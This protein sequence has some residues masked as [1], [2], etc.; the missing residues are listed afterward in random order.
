VNRTLFQS[1]S[2]KK[3]NPSL[4]NRKRPD[5]ED[6]RSTIGS[7]IPLP[8]ENVSKFIGKLPT[9][10]QSPV[11][12]EKVKQNDAPKVHPTAVLIKHAVKQLRKHHKQ[13]SPKQSP[14]RVRK[15]KTAYWG[16]GARAAE[17]S[18]L[19]T[20][21]FMFIAL[22]CGFMRYLPDLL[23]EIGVEHGDPECARL[24]TWIRDS[25][26]WVTGVRC[27]NAPSSGGR[28]I[29]AVGNIQEGERY[30]SIP[31]STWFWEASVKEFSELS[32]ILD[33]DE[34]LE[35]ELGEVWADSGDPVRLIVALAYERLH[36]ND[37]HWKPFIDSMPQEPTSPIWW[38]TDELE[39]FNSDVLRD[40]VIKLNQTITKN[41]NRFMPTLSERYPDTFDLNVFTLDLWKWSSLHMYGRAFDATHPTDPD[42]RTWALIPVIDLVNHQGYPD[43]GYGDSEG[44]GPFTAEA[45]TCVRHGGELFHSYGASKSS[46]HY[47]LTY[48]FI[49]TGYTHS[50]YV[51]FSLGHKVEADLRDF[52]RIKNMQH[53]IRNFWYAGF[54]GVDGV[55]TEDFI[56]TYAF[57]VYTK[58]HNVDA[59]NVIHDQ[60]YEA[61]IRIATKRVLELLLDSVETRV[62]NFA[63]TYEQDF[64]QLSGPFENYNT[65]VKL[66]A[67]TRFKRI[68]LTLIGTLRFR[69]ASPEFIWNDSWGKEEQPWLMAHDKEDISHRNRVSAVDR[70]LFVVRLPSTAV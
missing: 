3:K 27:I 6:A 13:A 11:R 51:A 64:E 9:P 22:S 70:A 32:E 30:A 43:G 67:R 2:E 45:T 62:A 17:G 69:I 65:W 55:I 10:T 41:Y 59:A 42:L 54:A 20:L 7:P 24:T 31:Q 52:E 14:S 8:A 18:L 33:T 34:F 23:D 44:P 4:R 29:V 12:S 5:G 47:L 15:T 37:S 28:G 21:V 57:Y 38:P 25:G 60:D 35:T 49:P 56:R 19:P 48:G 66:T 58:Q 26:G 40:Q 16:R 53:N 68:L 36:L 1:S 63:T 50:D 46:T 39:D 61:N